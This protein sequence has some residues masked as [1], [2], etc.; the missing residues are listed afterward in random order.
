MDALVRGPAGDGEDQIAPPRNPRVSWRVSPVGL[1]SAGAG[2]AVDP[3]PVR[4]EIPEAGVLDRLVL[5][6]HAPAACQAGQVEIRVRAA[7][8]NFRDVLC[9]LG[10][11]PGE[12]GPWAWSA[13]ARSWQWAMGSKEFRPGD[14]VMG[15]ALG[16]FATFVT[17]EA[18]FV[19]LRP[20]GMLPEEAATIPSAFLTAW[21]ALHRL[22]RIAPGERVL[23]HA[24]R[25]V[26]ALRRCRSPAGRGPRSSPRRETQRSGNFLRSLGVRHV[27]D[28]RSVAFAGE[29]LEATGGHGVHIVLNSLTG[30]FIPKSL[31]VLATGGRFIELGQREVWSQERVARSGPVS[32]TPPS[33]FSG[34]LRAIPELVASLWRDR[35][36]GAP[37]GG[38]TPLPRRDFPTRGGGLRPSAT[39]RKRAR[40]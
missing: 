39:W 16:S 18:R 32:H 12:P 9:A 37:E 2:T 20:A 38:L 1:P 29:T 14:E 17:T 11:Y 31:S 26:W 22:A 34:S 28:S 24:A 23:I 36:E 8:L 27:M 35:A 25:A 6:P 21:Y 5:R 13:R 4:L 10:M 15:L 33:T 7:G 19:V 3:I 30:E 40:R